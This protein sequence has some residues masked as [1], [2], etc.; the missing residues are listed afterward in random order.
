MLSSSIALALLSASVDARRIVTNIT[1]APEVVTPGACADFA[2]C[3]ALNMLGDC[4]PNAKGK[5]LGC[6]PNKPKKDKKAKKEKKAKAP[7]PV[8]VVTPAPAK[9]P[10]GPMYKCETVPTYDTDKYLTCKGDARKPWRPNEAYAACFTLAAY[11]NWL[12]PKKS[13][14]EAWF[15]KSSAC[16]KKKDRDGNYYDGRCISKGHKGYAKAKDYVGGEIVYNRPSVLIKGKPWYKKPSYEVKQPPIS[17][18][19]IGW[20]PTYKKLAIGKWCEVG[21]PKQGWTPGE[22]S[23]SGTKISV[24]SYNLYW[25]NLFGKKNG[26]GTFKDRKTGQR[27]TEDR[28]AGQLM[29]RNGPFD[30]MGFQECSDIKRVI[31]DARLTGKVEYHAGHNAIA[32]AWLKDV[33]TH[34]EGGYEDVTEDHYRAEWSGMRG[35]VWDRL[36]HKAGGD[37]VFFINHHGPLPDNSGGYCGAHATVYN[38]LRVIAERAHKGDKV[39]LVGDFNAMGASTTTEVLSQHLKNSYHGRSFDGVDKFYHNCRN[40]INVTRAKNWGTGGSDHD[41][42]TVYYDL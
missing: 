31:T 18:D 26:R 33:W 1:Q 28:S 27:F 13:V 24:L 5:F 8:R 21:I 41:A 16:G 42:L 22:C 14:G 30:I 40:E 38:I 7:K 32:N 20:N 34:L 4:C 39:I 6:C 35:I 23:K 11:V 2:P 17:P 3:A 12:C 36:K 19:A 9:P 10:L 37:T 29:E 25:W 15:D